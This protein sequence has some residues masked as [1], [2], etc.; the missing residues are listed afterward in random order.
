MLGLMNCISMT[1][2]TTIRK[3]LAAS[4]MSAFAPEVYE[5]AACDDP[6]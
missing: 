4:L 1:T 2:T 5:V 6:P 3:D